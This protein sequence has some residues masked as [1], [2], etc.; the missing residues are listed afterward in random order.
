MVRVLF[1]GGLG[2]SGT[3]LLERV[4]GEL[5]RVAPLGEVL[6]MWRRDVLDNERC[7]CGQPF[8]SCPFW[9]EVGQRAY[10]GWGNLDV[11][12]VLQ[13]QQ[14]VDR[15]RFIPKLAARKLDPKMSADVAE[16]VSH[17]ER[18]YA[19]AA[20]VAGSDV[21]IDSSKNASLAYCLRWSTALDM[22]VLHVVR[23]SRGVAY[24]WTKQVARPETDGGDEMTRYSPSRSAVLWN[25]HNTAFAL[26]GRRGIDV[27]RLRYEELIAE[28]V[29][30]TGTLAAWM[31]VPAGPA[32]LE[33]VSDG[34]VRLGSC[35]SAAG[36]PMRFKT[37][38]LELR[39]DDAWRTV[40]RDCHHRIIRPA[41]GAEGTPFK[42][43]VARAYAE[44]ALV[45]T[46][47]EVVEA[48]T[49]L[50]RTVRRL[51]VAQAMHIHGPVYELIDASIWRA[52]GYFLELARTDLGLTTTSTSRHPDVNLEDIDRELFA[53]FAAAHAEA[54]QPDHGLGRSDATVAA[55]R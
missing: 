46:G 38:L 3:T 27:R 1:I 31:G 37:G 23:D 18:V 28:P 11:R 51:A 20:D 34:R 13:L 16:Y 50:A 44:L 4:L 54:D 36:N 8:A 17:Y 53:A 43:A 41:F 42:Q 29:A 26:L 12:R 22:K 14:A 15:T 10:G 39:R 33:F 7:A 52:E 40:F 30:T 49:L 21:V 48:A 24:S 2:R 45:A 55:E 32:D 19:A 25:A 35:H 47:H 9:T 6:H 5:P